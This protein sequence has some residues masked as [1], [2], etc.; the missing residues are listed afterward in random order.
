[1]EIA[2]SNGMDVA[3]LTYYS[4]NAASEYI[5]NYKRRKAEEEKRINVENHNSASASIEETE[6]AEDSTD[7]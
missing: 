1:A 4:L 7:N 2:T 3:E 6:S 5:E